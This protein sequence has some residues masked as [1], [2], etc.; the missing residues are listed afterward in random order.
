MLKTARA[1]P[2]RLVI[3][4]GDMIPD[5]GQPGRIGLE[6]YGFALPYMGY[7]VVGLGELELRA[8]KMVDEQAIHDLGVPLICANIVREKDNKLF[9]GKPY[10]VKKTP[11]G[12]RVAVTAVIGEAVVYP[13]MQKDLGI[14]VVP[15]VES[16][17]QNVPTMRK[18]ADVVI[19]LAHV[20]AEAA[21]VIASQIDVFGAGQGVDVILSSHPSAVQKDFQKVGSIVIMHSKNNCKYV[22]KLTLDIDAQGKITAA[23]GEYAPL[24]DKIEDDVEIAR[25]IQ[26]TV[27]RVRQ[28]YQTISATHN[29]QLNASGSEPP[30]FV[31]ADKCT[32]CH[33]DIGKSWKKTDHAKAYD[34]L[35]K[36]DRASLRNPYCLSCHTTGFDLPGGFRREAETPHL[37]SVQCESCHGA[38]SVHVEKPED[39]GYGAISQD[40]CLQCHD[41]ANSPDFDYVKYLPKIRH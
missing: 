6:F 10:I 39:K 16:I 34:A 26:T 20:G 25:L 40:T 2:N 15:P 24:H 27:K 36:R 4:L 28:H 13:A 8:M 30:T 31:G 41:K 11:S 12:L 3:E 35:K 7:D 5:A 17:K 14:K 21:A 1:V 9:V 38:G 29:A 18:E 23:N 33:G 37:K 22:G 32:K 19:V